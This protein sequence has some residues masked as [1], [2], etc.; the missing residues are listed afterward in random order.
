M[1]LC[2]I[3]QLENPTISLFEKSKGLYDV[4]NYVRFVRTIDLKHL[5]KD[6]LDY[7][8]LHGWIKNKNI[9]K[10]LLKNILITIINTNPPENCRNELLD[11]KKNGTN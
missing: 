7:E 10:F 3:N 1:L 8:N 2:W 4:I 11:N 5:S 9:S 6:I